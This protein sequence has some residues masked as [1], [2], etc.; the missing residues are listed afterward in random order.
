MLS[1]SRVSF[2]IVAGL[3][4]APA[5]GH[6]Q[7]A[8]PAAKQAASAAP[9][10]AAKPAA[11]PAKPAPP[12]VS[13]DPKDWLTRL[14]KMDATKGM[15]TKSRADFD[16][17]DADAAYHIYSEIFPQIKSEPA[18]RGMFRIVLAK[19]KD[20]EV[21]DRD[22][23]RLL[24]LFD[25]ALKD[26][27][28]L[29]RK[30]AI[31]SISPLLLRSFAT[32]AAWAEWRKANAA[33]PLPQIIREDCDALAAA[34]S[35]A[36]YERKM[37]IY[38]LMARAAYGSEY[39]LER[40]DGKI[41][42]KS[43]INGLNAMRRKAVQ[44]SG[45]FDA[46]TLPLRGAIQ[47]ELTVKS[48]LFLRDY[49][50][51][52]AQM[53]RIDPA[54][55]QLMETRYATPDAQ[56]GISLDL[57]FASP[58]DW[59]MPLLVKVAQNNYLNSAS[60]TIIS[61]LTR[62]KDVRALPLLIDL[63]P[64]ASG[65]DAIQIKAAIAEL[66]LKPETKEVLAKRDADG[67]R[68]WWAKN[69][70]DYPADAQNLTLGPLKTGAEAV[71]VRIENN[72]QEYGMDGA[73]MQQF[74]ALNT[75]AKYRVL[76]GVWGAEMS[77]YAKQ[78]LLY[79]FTSGNGDPD[80]K[81]PKHATHGNPRLL[82]A[83]YLGM[84]DA[85]GDV[86]EATAQIIFQKTLQSFPDAASFL[87][88]RKK[89]AGKPMKELETEGAKA[90][91]ARLTAATEGEKTDLL[92]RI[93]S[94][95][96]TFHSGTKVTF[97]DG[98]PVR[99]I[100]VGPE[101]AERRKIL[102]DGG[103]VAQAIALLYSRNEASSVAATNFLELFQ[104][105]DADL[106]KIEAGIKPVYT[107]WVVQGDR[108]Y[109]PMYSFMLLF[110][111]PWVG[112]LLTQA[113]QTSGNNPYYGRQGPLPEMMQSDDKRTIPALISALDSQPKPQQPPVLQRLAKITGVKFDAKQ[114]TAFWQKWWND[115]KATLPEEVRV[116]KLAAPKSPSETLATKLL[117][118]KDGWDY[119][120]YYEFEASDADTQWATLNAV[121]KKMTNKQLKSMLFSN[122]LN[123]LNSPDGNM[124]NF[125]G[126][127]AVKLKPGEAER[128]ALELLGMGISD[129]DKD[130]R[131]AA[132]SSLF[133]FAMRD[134]KD[135]AAYAAW[136]KEIGDKP[137]KAV[138]KQETRD[139]LARLPRA[140]AKTL[141]PL[142]DSLQQADWTSRSRY[143]Y[144]Y[145]NAPDD[146][147]VT[148]TGL[149]G[150]RRTVATEMKLPDT[151][152]RLMKS[153]QTPEVNQKAMTLLHAFLPGRAVYARVEPDAA[154]ILP[155]L[156]HKKAG[157]YSIALSLLGPYRGKWATDLLLETAKKHYIEDTYSV[158]NVLSSSRSVRVV[159]TLIAIL[160]DQ[161]GEWYMRRSISSALSRLTHI[162]ESSSHTAAWWREWWK[163]NRAQMPEEARN[164]TIPDLQM[165]NRYAK[166]FSIKRGRQLETI[167]RDP[168]RA[169]WRLS[170]GLLITEKTKVKAVAGA[171]TVTTT[172]VSNTTAAKKTA[173]KEP[174]GIPMAD[175]PGLLVVLSDG[176][177]DV[178]L[179]ASYWQD[180]AGRGF[181]GKFL[182]A[183][184]SP[185]K[186]REKQT[187][188]WL[189]RKN[190][191]E[192]PE[193]A[194]TT[195]SLVADVARDMESKY[196]INPVHVY[197]IGAG[198]G[199]PAAY[200][201]SLE[202]NTPFHGFLLAQS[203]FRSA[204]L[205]PLANAKNRRYYL[206]HSRD[207][208]RTPY[209]G[210]TLAQNT[211][212]AQGAAVKLSKATPNPDEN[213]PA[214]WEETVAGVKWLEA[215]P[216]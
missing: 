6:A 78:Q 32:P 93:S 11:P 100:T 110:H 186:W 174:A 156:A 10:A 158:M 58:G 190:H 72:S 177:S 187:T 148:A 200:A 168:H 29:L 183:L 7:N 34:M 195:E 201:C 26:S 122:T 206:L 125:F 216:R 41:S 164:E 65:Q 74:Q 79:T 161:D 57:L 101:I 81:D 184:V 9:P 126:Q 169:Y 135:A 69:K 138:V 193:A 214:S 46:L 83:L 212:R 97:K 37:G 162:T 91:M 4:F 55:R 208:K 153:D 52:E 106:P 25:I 54:L 189:T 35:T 139:I 147:P 121:W 76:Q 8:A 2:R 155:L 124:V 3:L 199:G 90:F 18:R 75:E 159:P 194:F 181:G 109:T 66:Q 31:Q 94:R 144:Y 136:R 113:A 142:L 15:D 49:R 172:L 12:P 80:P 154:R 117:A 21:V 96:I 16:G 77:Y 115:N 70:A 210:A 5:L 45:L 60:A 17:L 1:Y 28:P 13:K 167:A 152:A 123:A 43:K 151:L 51:D 62:A 198:A 191:A 196:P 86:Q 176:D 145:N 64:T 40:A 131:Q 209:F 87:L 140:D 205:P 67:W 146:A 163:K 137:M 42:R 63:L 133:N 98:K 50:A 204:Q 170:S 14:G 68:D 84:T 130:I 20:P 56:V 166:T 165:G 173:A 105:E 85:D 30:T 108:Q 128:R 197:L 211:L 134:I 102:A 192:V 53:R 182:V 175:R 48:V 179:Q 92:T 89:S 180:V 188:L 39:L 114:D 132:S 112:D 157:N 22:P 24:T 88:W 103:I 160:E 120:L 143:Y 95:A 36:T 38:A 150:I 129:A 99:T 59:A 111:S 213:Q 116:M 61:T 178:A 215:A 171:K 104:P 27:S 203:A 73:A 44:D 23:A 141:P 119:Q 71:I 127:T 47:E 118:S 149:A 33:K 202:A 82:D 185:P 19:T 107:R 207:D